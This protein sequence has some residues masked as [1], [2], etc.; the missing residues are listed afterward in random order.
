VWV[1]ARLLRE[2]GVGCLARGAALLAIAV[3]PVQLPSGWG[4]PT[5][6]ATALSLGGVP[7]RPA[8][9]PGRRACS[10]PRLLTKWTVVFGLVASVHDALAQGRRRAAVLILAS[11]GAWPGRAS[12]WRRG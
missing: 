9:S 4:R 1:V 2:L 7:G 5:C 3:V 11:P 10:S 12:R 6:V 8:P